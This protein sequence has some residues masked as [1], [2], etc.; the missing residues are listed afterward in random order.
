M[1]KILIGLII[2]LFYSCSATINL[3]N[4]TND[5]K[6]EEQIIYD[7]ADKISDEQLTFIKKAYNWN[8]E[9]ILIIDYVQPIE[10]SPCELDYKSIPNSGKKWR[11]D[12][13]SKINIEGCLNI[14]V[15]GSGEIIKESKLDNITYFDDKNDFFYKNYFSRKKSCFGILVI[16][17][18]GYYIQHNG[19]TSARQ[20]AKYIEKIKTCYNTVQN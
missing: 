11:K 2:I 7:Y 20:V 13:Y 17:N 5:S 19:H 18:D 12:F 3:E 16:N 14:Q 9:K 15:F 4:Q 8:D 1:K 10:I 6:N